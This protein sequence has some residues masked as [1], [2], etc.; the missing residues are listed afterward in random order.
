LVK[1]IIGNMNRII[2]CLI[3]ISVVMTSPAFASLSWTCPNCGQT[4]YFDDRD[5][6]YMNNWI[7]IHLDACRGGSSSSSSTD[8]PYVRPSFEGA[9]LLGGMAGGVLGGVFGL[10]YGE[11]WSWA[12]GGA[13]IGAGI[14]GV[15]WWASEPPSYSEAYVDPSIEQHN[16][17]VRLN[18]EANTYY[19]SGDYAKA[20]E[21]YQTALDKWPDNSVI[22]NNYQGAKE[23]L[24]QNKE[25]VDSSVVDLRDKTSDMVDI[26][27]VKGVNISDVT[28]RTPVDNPAQFKYDVL[29]DY[30]KVFNERV[31]GQNDT[32]QG[33]IRSLKIKEPPSPTK[34]ISDLAAGDVILIAP[35]GTMSSILNK[36]DRW[37]SDSS[38]SPASHTATY[39]GEKYGKRFFLNNTPE[40]GPVIMEE[41]DFLAKYYGRDMNVAT[42]VGEPLSKHEG[43]ELWKGAKEMAKAGGYGIKALPATNGNDNMVCSES[44][45][46]LLLRAGRNVPETK[47]EIKKPFVKFSPADFYDEQQYFIVHR[48]GMNK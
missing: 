9:L 3:L 5:S 48:L 26:N 44:S 13:V 15:V 22:Q 31:Q 37:A 36:V 16:E 35:N 8:K 1:S 46:W 2:T 45:R 42:L 40:E 32:A 18:E 47:D 6:D 39:L 12:I 25:P 28:V 4:Y 14:T 20:M 30:S 21:L 23:K 43:E 19:S 29:T 34:N 27:V 24:D 38:N 33:I 7:P 41:K 17:A 11:P 10:V